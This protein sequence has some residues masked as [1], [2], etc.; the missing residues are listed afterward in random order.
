MAKKD[1]NDAGVE[2]TPAEAARRIR[3]LGDSAF[4]SAKDNSDPISSL[5][6]HYPSDNEA[7]EAIAGT[8]LEPI[9]KTLESATEPP[10]PL[11]LTLPDA[12]VVA[13]CAL[14]SCNGVGNGVEGLRCRIQTGYR[15]Q[16]TNFYIMK[17]APSGAGK[18]LNSDLIEHLTGID[19]PITGGSLEGMMDAMITDPDGLISLSEMG[20]YFDRNSWQSRLKF[21]LT[22]IFHAGKFRV[23]TS[24]RSAKKSARECHCCYPTLKASVQ[25]KALAEFGNE[26]DKNNGFLSRFLISVVDYP[27]SAKPMYGADGIAESLSSVDMWRQIRGDVSLGNQAKMKLWDTID[28]YDGEAAGVFNRHITAYGPRIGLAISGTNEIL[29]EHAERALVLVLWFFDQANRVMNLIQDEKGEKI[30]QRILYELRSGGGQCARSE[31]LRKVRIGSRELNDHLLTLADRG[32]VRV[33]EKP[34]GGRPVVEIRLENR[35]DA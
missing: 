15:G 9:L 18:D 31:M 13:S 26:S 8:P 27:V 30:R 14:T 35:N 32:D 7:R 17:V 24:T 10:L 1:A 2:F 22:E 12:L 16:G 33:I 3:E 23:A 34:T 29:V 21:A 11:P 28:K 19:F 6:I 5:R 4:A 20:V 25:N